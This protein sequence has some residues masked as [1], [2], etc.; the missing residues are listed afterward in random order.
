MALR[1]AR[2][3]RPYTRHPKDMTP[4][5]RLH[6]MRSIEGLEQL[7][8]DMLDSLNFREAIPSEWHDIWEGEER[9]A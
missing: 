5:E 2:T 6:W 9:D 3:P 1:E 4:K 8:F 7:E